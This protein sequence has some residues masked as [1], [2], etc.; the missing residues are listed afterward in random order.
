MSLFPQ[1]SQRVFNTPI[2]I[3]PGKAEVIVAALAS[4]LGVAKISW[5]NGASFAAHEWED[6]Y[7]DEE[8]NPRGG[9]DLVEGVAV[10]QVRGTTVQRTGSLRPYSGMTGYDGIRQNFLMA[11]TDPAVR[12]IAFDMDSPGGEVAGCFDLVDTIYKARGVKPIAAILSENA[13]SATYA[14]ASTADP[15]RVYIP[16]TGGCGSCGVIYAHISYEGFLDH[17]GIEVTLVTKGDLKGDCS[18]FKN[19][20]KDTLA[21]LQADVNTV[22][23]LFDATVARNRGISVKSVFDTQAGT[24]MGAAGVDI[25]FA[26]KV[27][28]PDEAFRDLLA[29]LD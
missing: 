24:F 11:L 25:G 1:L 21:R 26:D 5:A 12:A 23:D 6:D 4:R 15:G 27:M 2:M 19:L 20:S 16:R 7:E 8:V 29:D 17:Q 28:A 18:E 9:Y 13:Y 10:I 14:L 3:H 22:G